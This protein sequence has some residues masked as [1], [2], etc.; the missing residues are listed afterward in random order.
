MIPTNRDIPLHE[1]ES[2]IR[3]L[4][5]HTERLIRRIDGTAMFCFGMVLG[6]LLAAVAFVICRV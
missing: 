2:G 4:D 6:A 3:N 5:S 1:Y